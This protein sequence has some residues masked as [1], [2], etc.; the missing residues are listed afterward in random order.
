MKRDEAR[1][2]RI[3]NQDAKDKELDDEENGKP[4]TNPYLVQI[5]LCE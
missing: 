2:K 1:A 5:E 3:A 4:K